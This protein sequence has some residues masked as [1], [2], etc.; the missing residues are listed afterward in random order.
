M[1]NVMRM[2]II[3]PLAASLFLAACGGDEERT[4]ASAGGAA[5]AAAGGDAAAGAPATGGA[6]TASGTMPQLRP[7]NY[8]VRVNITRFEVPGMPPEV[9]A[10]M[11]QTMA[12]VGQQVQNQ[13]ITPEQSAQSME[14]VYKRLGQGNCTT[15]RMAMTGGQISGAMRCDSGGGRVMAMTIEGAINA[16]G[17][18]TNVSLIAND[19]NLPQ[20]QIETDMSVTMVRTGDCAAGAAAR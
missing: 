2:L 20:G 1:E 13:C 19:P 11:R 8:E 17:S 15:E 16:D 12:G 10:Q 14:D 6:T 18:T 4:A 5:G 9:A 3:L 7:G